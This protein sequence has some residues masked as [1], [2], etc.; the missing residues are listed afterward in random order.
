MGNDP[1]ASVLRVFA[2]SGPPLRLGGGEG[3]S[4]RA[5][6]VVLKP[7][8]DPAE[9]AWLGR[10]LPTIEQRGFRLAMPA[11]ARDGRWVVDGWC[12]Q[13]AVEGV[14]AERWL[15][16]LTVCRTFHA[17]AIHLPRPASIDART[18]P[19]SVGDRVA[20]AELDPPVPHPLLSRL[21]RV[22][23]G[24]DL[25]SQV[26]HGDLT[27]NVLF[28]DLA[29][30]AIIDVTPYWRPAGYAEAIVVGDAVHWRGAQPAPL[31]D[32]CGEIPDFGQLFV[33]AVIFRLVTTLIFGIDDP[34]SYERVVL[35]AEELAD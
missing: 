12:A 17:A 25:G 2:T 5:G 6:G 22:R 7:C 8:D 35:L 27:E 34:A 15:E 18:H 32:R 26:I 1:A 20:W 10:W 30:P 23:R 4:F 16:V 19:W 24:V 28:A 3:R 31:L 9:W 21:L 29:P 13:A 14:H 33:R 11:R